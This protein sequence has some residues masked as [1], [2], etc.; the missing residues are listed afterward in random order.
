M[1]NSKTVN[2]PEF[3]SSYVTLFQAKPNSLKLDKKTG[4]PVMQFSVQALFKKGE[5]LTGLKK[6][7]KAAIIERWGADESKWPSKVDP[8]T[9]KKSLDIRMPFRDQSEREKDGELPT[10]CVAGAIFCTFSTNENPRQPKPAVFD[11]R[12]QKVS[13]EDQ[14]KIYSGCW[15]KA[16]VTAGAYPPKG[17]TGIK[18]GVTFY[19]NAVQKVRDDEPL[20]GRPNV[21]KAFQPIETDESSDGSATGM[22]SDLT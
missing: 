12:N 19:L 15:M 18:P 20:S 5:D 11:Q 21:E 14:H 8:E 9:G 22:F 10:G 1:E 6:A 17:V 13:D 4:Q 3:R 16:N 2:T 7:V